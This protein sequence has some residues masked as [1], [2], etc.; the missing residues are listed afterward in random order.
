MRRVR[1]SVTH[2]LTCTC[3]VTEQPF[4]IPYYATLLRLL[5][6][7]VADAEDTVSTDGLSALGKQVME[8]FWKGFQAFLDKLA[9]REI[10]FCVRLLQGLKIVFTS[11]CFI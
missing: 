5:H 9:W 11:S 8:D 6:E 3:S 1:V 2:T 10:R 7:P 4:K